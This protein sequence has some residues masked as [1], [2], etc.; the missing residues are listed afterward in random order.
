M[1]STLAAT[2]NQQ[3]AIRKT[4]EGHVRRSFSFAAP[5]QPASYRMAWFTL[6]YRDCRDNIRRSLDPPSR[7]LLSMT[8]H[9]NGSED[10]RPTI[11]DWLTA[12]LTH[13][14]D[15]FVCRVFP[16]RVMAT[17]THV[18][19]RHGA[20]YSIQWKHEHGCPLDADTTLAAARGGHLACLQYAHEHG[21]HWHADTTLAAARGG[22]LACLQYAHEHGCKWDA[23]TTWE[24]ARGG[25]L[26]CLQYAHEHGCHWHVDTIWEAAHGG[27]LA[28]LQYAHEHG[29]PWHADTTCAAARHGHLAC[30]QYA[31]TTGHD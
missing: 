7:I 2:R 18:F 19:A 14:Y 22:H 13:G 25:H 10:A 12:L 26:A 21:C 15:T 16:T 24:A 31:H 11:H 9:A 1:N 3:A 17:A 29:C 4:S 23:Y 8:C 20:I 30:V 27:H 5:D 28:C 6:L